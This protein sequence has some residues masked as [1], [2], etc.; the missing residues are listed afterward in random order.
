MQDVHGA[1]AVRGHQARSWLAL[2]I[3]AV[4]AL[5]MLS[6]VLGRFDTLGYHDWDIHAAYRHVTTVS[7]LE[8][9]EAPWWHPWLCGGFPAFGHPEGATNFVSPYL[10]LYLLADVRVALRLELLGATL[11]GLLGAFFLARRFT[12][13]AALG[14][15]VATVAFLNGRWA[16]QAAV[17]HTW[18]FQYVWLPWVLLFFDRS[19]E[20]GRM[21]EAVYA[22]AF[23][24]LMVFMGG[25]YPA[26]HTALLLIVYAAVLAV[27]RRSLRPVLALAVAGFTALGFSAPKLA[28]V[29]DALSQAPRLIESTEAIGLRSLLVMLTDRSQLPLF[30]PI[31]VPDYGWH[32]WGIYVGW[33]A[34]ALLLLGV[35]LARGHRERALQ[36]SALSLLVLGLG[37]FHPWSPWALLQQVPPFSSQHVP[38]RFHFPMLLVAALA[39]ASWAEGL[40]RRLAVR[41]HRLEAILLVLVALLAVDT[42]W[43]ARRSFATAFLMKPPAAIDAAEVFE[44]R[45]RS[46]VQYQAR[47]LMPPA[48]LSMMANQGLIECYGVPGSLRKGARGIEDADYRGPAWVDGGPGSAELEVWSPNRAVLRYRGA[49]LGSLLVYNMN[50]DPSWRANGE[51]ALEHEHALAVRLEQ[52]EGTVEFRYVPRTLR[53]SLWL[54]G[55]TLVGCLLVGWLRARVR[56]P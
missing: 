13:S 8:Y 42:A 4:A 24:A 36:V 22:G 26:P 46:P 29:Y 3:L 19:T 20:T 21:R 39:F 49:Q 9:R 31:R 40:L 56:R 32:E 25:I 7:L 10:P 38:S 55:L 28:A 2:L 51:P 53:Y 15:F 43:V 33:V 47:D 45:R 48:L 44:H 6:H 1:R 35:L 30:P 12:A 54:P 27:S 17:G 52:A 11:T 50:F 14:V 34:L 18:H 37:A 16:L 23:L 41:R 5:L